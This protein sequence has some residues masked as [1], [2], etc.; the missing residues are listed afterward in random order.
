MTL[1][2]G[3]ASNACYLGVCHQL[4]LVA[5]RTSVVAAGL[6]A[7]CE[8]RVSAVS[9]NSF[10]REAPRLLLL[11]ASLNLADILCIPRDARIKIS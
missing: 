2:A 3:T 9:R 8:A 4:R 6:A 10:L 11:V 7:D 1:K 5:V